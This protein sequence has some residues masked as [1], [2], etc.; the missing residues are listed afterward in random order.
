M[1]RDPRWTEVDAYAAGL[2]GL[3]DTDMAAIVS[4]S[5]AADL[6]SIQVSA[7]QGRFLE[8]LVR[9]CRGNRVLEI[10][11]LGGFSTAFLARG[12][13]PDG[14][15]VTLEVDPRHAAVARE[16]LREAGLLDR[17]EIVEGDAHASLAAMIE[18]EVDPFD[19]VF[20]DAEKQ[21][22]P[23][24]FEAVLRLSRPGTILVADNVVRGGS[25]LDADSTDSDVTGVR[26]FNSLVA[27]TP[28]V[29]ATI[30][31]TVGAKGHDG[32]LLAVLGGGRPARP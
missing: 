4:R 13:G 9:G 27:S 11:T 6:P 2:F 12:V 5:E 20:L 15:V 32:F 19:F 30:L 25:V 8:I 7:C 22:Y 26:A 28:G 1:E 18:E 21:G 10:G 29:T 14:L 16:G 24:Y 3:L 17:V 31:Q 23:S